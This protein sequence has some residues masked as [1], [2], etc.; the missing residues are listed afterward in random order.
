MTRMRRIDADR[1]AE[2]PRKS[3][4]SAS[5]AYLLIYAFIYE[6]FLNLTHWE[7][8]PATLVFRGTLGHENDTAVVAKRFGF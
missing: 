7:K 3:A 6:R 2:N 8:Q 4:A 1:A 5:S